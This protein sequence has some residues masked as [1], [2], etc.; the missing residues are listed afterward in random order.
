MK[1][2]FVLFSLIFVLASP[3]FAQTDTG[4]KARADY[5]RYNYAK[6]EYEI[7][8]R[9]GKTLFTAVY[10]PNDTS[11]KYP[12]L[13][14]RT[15]YSA[16][17]YGVSNYAEKLGPDA[18]FEEEGFIFVV[19]DVRGRYRS[20]G[21]YVNVRP[22]DAYKRGKGA[23]DDATDTYDTI[24]WLVK[25]I[26]GNNGKAG[27]WGI[28]YPGYYA[29]VGTVNAH[30]A[31]KAVSP[32]APVTDW[33]FDDFRRNGAFVPSMAFR[34]FDS[35]DNQPDVKYSHPVNREAD[36]WTH[37]GYQFY[38]DLGPLS[39]VNKDYFKG[40]RPFWNDLIAHPNYDDFWQAR[41]ILQHLK[42]T[43]PAILVVGGWYDTEDLYGPLATYQT[44]SQGNGLDHVK[45][46]MGPWFH[47]QWARG[48]GSS[49]GEAQ[50]GFNTSKWIQENT[51][52]PFFIQN[53]K[54]SKTSVL[55]TATIF[56]T[57]ANRWRKF[58]EWPPKAATEDVMYFAAGERL[59]AEASDNGGGS[60]EYISDPNKPVPHSKVIGP[61]W[62][63]PYMAEDQRFTA[64]RP[65]VLV[66]ETEILTDDMTLVGALNLD[67]KVS[68]TGSAA[69]FVVKLVDVFPGKD[70]NTN[71]LDENTGNRHE[72]VRWGSIRGRF[73]NSMS[74][75]EPF[76]PS[77]VATVKFDLYDVMHTFKRGHKIQIQVQSSMFPF[78]DR[79]P[80]TYVDNIVDAKPEDF[81]KAEHRL[82]HDK[83][84]ISSVRLHVLEK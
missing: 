9:D 75:P 83:V 47:G 21:E 27:M 50:F 28:S 68:T 57:G 37:D 31:L 10:V 36:L 30:P 23:V 19:Q 63:R 34:F 35:F 29:S 14:V 1:N 39:N 76:T 54:G 46:V 24:D 40:T 79:N 7:A 77:E 56:E 41:N 73:R 84:N 18:I 26:K 51:V 66:F 32:Q 13:M 81:I 78:L 49:M 6:Y 5:I 15:P 70:E 12:F 58:D 17:P 69:D 65:D 71:A 33:F 3:V 8:M 72:L 11:K 64:R 59:V 44:M 60:S 62:D 22:Q 48:D 4:A 42:K 67:L 61:G 25:N 80:Q 38:L 52:L 82:Y 55:P 53:L 20:E 45:L 43:K 16:R 74:A 2:L